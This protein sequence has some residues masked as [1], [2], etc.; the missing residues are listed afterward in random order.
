MRLD[1]ALVL[2]IIEGGCLRLTEHLHPSLL[3]T[4][5][6]GAGVQSSGNDTLIA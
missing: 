4:K 5:R 2:S 6:L 3:L 1:R